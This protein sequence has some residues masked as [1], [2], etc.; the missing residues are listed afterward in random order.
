MLR[1]PAHG[2]KR[3]VM[4]AR[5]L[6]G[7]PR[8]AWFEPAHSDGLVRAALQAGAYLVELDANRL[9][10]LDPSVAA[11]QLLSRGRPSPLPPIERKTFDALIALPPLVAVPKQLDGSPGED[12]R[13]VRNRRSS[14]LRNAKRTIKVGT[15]VLAS[16][17]PDDG[18]WEAE[19]VALTNDELLL[20]WRDF[21]DLALFTKSAAAISLGPVAGFR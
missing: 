10:Q 17:S 11:G 19:V 13:A 21:P 20:R 6:A 14:K 15:I 3:L 16:V 2:V 8:G 18:W 12:S 7:E 1:Q 9:R 5:G 4:L